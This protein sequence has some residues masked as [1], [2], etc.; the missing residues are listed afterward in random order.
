MTKFEFI[1]NL[2]DN[3]NHIKEHYPEHL[4]DYRMGVRHISLHAVNEYYKPIQVDN[5]TLQQYMMELT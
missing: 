3:I 1:K 5:T 2:K 4:D